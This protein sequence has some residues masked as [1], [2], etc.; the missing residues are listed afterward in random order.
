MVER[1]GRLREGERERERERKKRKMGDWAQGEAG[2]GEVSSSKS[3]IDSLTSLSSL[4]M[5]LF[6]FAPSLSYIEWL[7]TPPGPCLMHALSTNNLTT[8]L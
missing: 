4:Q 8:G 6:R 3:S 5:F 1:V 2:V 7:W